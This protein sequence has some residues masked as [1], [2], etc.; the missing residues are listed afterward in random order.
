MR[1]S[2]VPALHTLSPAEAR[3]TMNRSRVP[4]A[5]P[6][7]ALERLEDHLVPGAAG[8]LTVRLY[9]PHDLDGPRPLVLHFHQGGF[10][11]GEL[12][13]VGDMQTDDIAA[14]D[15]ALRGSLTPVLAV[16]R[17]TND[18]L[19]LRKMNVDDEGG[20]HFRYDQVYDGEY[21]R[22]YRELSWRHLKG[23]L[24]DT[25]PAHAATAR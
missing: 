14:A 15:Q 20:R 17:L 10:V 16:F 22:F 7:R 23:Y 8:D 3:A 24:P 13:K 25:R 11:V 1:A 4:A 2:H 5:L 12:A 21:W 18:D 19:V 9:A 6:P